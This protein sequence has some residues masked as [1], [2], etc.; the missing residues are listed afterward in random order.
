MNSFRIPSSLEAEKEISLLLKRLK[1]NPVI[2]IPE[3]SLLTKFE[4]IRFRILRRQFTKGYVPGFP[5]AV[6]ALHRV[7]RVISKSR[8][9]KAR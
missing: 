7:Y 4:S 6:G 3:K 8:K 1:K 2:D 5:S 9:N